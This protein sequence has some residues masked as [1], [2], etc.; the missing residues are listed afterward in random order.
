MTDID[1]SSNPHE[2]HGIRGWMIL[3]MLGTCISLFINLKGAGGSIDL[4]SKP[5]FS[6]YVTSFQALVYAELFV[7]FA[8]ACAL[9]YAIYLLFK[10]RAQYPVLFNALLLFTLVF[11]VAES[12]LLYSAYGVT[13]SEAS[14]KDVAK[15]FF[16]CLIWVP[17]MLRSRRV[18]NT[19]IH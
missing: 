14:G 12:W 7:T 6:K 18:R 10:H 19:F 4:I 9:G 1:I 2:P 16:A 13:L 5:D 3:P 11:S 15:S 17:Y 8:M